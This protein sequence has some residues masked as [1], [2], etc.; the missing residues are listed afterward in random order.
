MKVKVPAQQ[1]TAVRIW[2]CMHDTMHL[3]SITD[4]LYL[5]NSS[6]M[7]FMSDDRFS[8]WRPTYW[9]L[10]LKT[11]PP[12]VLGYKDVIA[13]GCGSDIDLCHNECALVFFSVSFQYT[14]S[15]TY[16]VMVFY[17]ESNWRNL[18][19][20]IS[21]KSTVINSDETVPCQNSNETLSCIVWSIVGQY[22]A[23]I[24]LPCS[25][26]APNPTAEAS[27]FNTNRRV[28]WEKSEIV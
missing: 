20:F 7:C 8:G 14:M 6:C 26:T 1:L 18:Y 12:E 17:V 5:F 25:N 10:H 27:V 21:A 13:I 4:N 3:I 16:K 9:I 24:S 28:L 19:F 11:G 23:D 22:L 2:S 15:K